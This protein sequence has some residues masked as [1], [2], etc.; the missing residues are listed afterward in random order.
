L[1]SREESVLAD[2]LANVGQRPAMVRVAYMLIYLFNR[3]R[4]L[5]LVTRNKMVLPITQ[6]DLADAM[7]L[8]IVHTNKTLKRL[9]AT[10]WFDWQRHTFVLKDEA[11]L[12]ELAEFDAVERPP[13]PFI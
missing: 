12:T 3:A 2:H 11:K 13:R 9:R 4:R 5:G 7:G 10:G 1:A 8:S 6:Q